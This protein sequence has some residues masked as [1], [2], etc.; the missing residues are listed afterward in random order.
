MDLSLTVTALG[1]LAAAV[2][3]DYKA[4]RDELSKRT[5]GLFTV[6]G[7]MATAFFALYVDRIVVK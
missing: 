7:A 6:L 4:V 1:F 3:A 5:A 2:V